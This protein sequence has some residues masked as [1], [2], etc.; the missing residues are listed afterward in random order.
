MMRKIKKLDFRIFLDNF[1]E[2]MSILT[3]VP[4]T[5]RLLVALLFAYLINLILGIIFYLRL[6]D[7]FMF[8]IIESL[9]E[10]TRDISI[11]LIFY[12]IFVKILFYGPFIF[13]FSI[14]IPKFFIEA[15][16]A[17]VTYN[18]KVV[19]LA[20]RRIEEDIYYSW[21]KED[22]EKV[23]KE[24]RYRLDHYKE[25]KVDHEELLSP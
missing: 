6:F 25:S 1:L 4:K 2:N 19:P 5:N 8:F 20:I 23:H 12:I 14:L 18:K 24:L 9:Y 21:T 3:H 15:S 17:L 16:N 22:V 13:A 7:S 10:I 11:T